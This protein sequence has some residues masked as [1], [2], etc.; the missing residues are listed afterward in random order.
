M[1][2]VLPAALA[3]AAISAPAI[4]DETTGEI[5]AYDRKAQIIVLK[6]KTIWQLAAD[7]LIPAD[8][9]AGDTVRISYD[10]AGED[11]LEK[12]VELTRN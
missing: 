1:R 10:S 9:A 8:L 6:D 12:I 5:V 4:A 7:T 11:G 3:L 2:F